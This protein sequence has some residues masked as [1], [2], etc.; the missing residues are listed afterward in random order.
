MADISTKMS[1]TGLS[2]YKSAMTQAQQSVKTLDAELKKNEAAYKASGDKEEYMSNKA[3]ILEQRIKAQKEAAKQAEQAL[4]AMTDQGVNPA[5]ASYQKMQ[6]AL[7]QAQTGVLDT[8]ASL[9]Q[10]TTGEQTAAAGADQL[11]ASVNG[12]NKKVSLDAVIGG[13]DK[14]TSGLEN[15]A[16]KALEVG[17]TIWNEIMNKAQW[18]DDTATAAMMLDMNVEDYQ[19]Y[20]AVFDTVGELTVQDWMKAKKKVQQAIYDP[21][22]DQIDVFA[23]LGLSTRQLGM[24]ENGMIPTL[25][26]KDW[27]TI[28][29]DA[30]AELQRRVQNG[31]LTQDQADV[32]AN[33]LFGKNFTSLKGLLKLGREGFEDAYNDQTAASEDAVN[34]MAELNDKIIELKDK[35]GKLETEVMAGLAPALTTASDVL[36]TLLDKL[37]TFLKSEA[38]QQLLDDMATAVSGL[39][40]DLSKI[41]P[42][43][44]V[45]GFTEVFNTIVE[46]FK[47]LDENKETLAGALGVIVAGWAGAKITGGALTIINMLNGLR[48]LG[49]I[50]GGGEAAGAAVGK[51]IGGGL[52]NTLLHAAAPAMAMDALVIGTAMLPAIIANNADWAKAEETRTRQINV[53]RT[54]DGTNAMWLERTA[55]AL[56]LQRDANG[57]IVKGALG[58][59]VWGNMGETEKALMDLSSRQNQQMAELQSIIAS[60]APTTSSGNETWNE[61]MRFWGGEEMD[62]SRIVALAESVAEA[63]EKSLSGENA[64][65]VEV[66]PVILTEMAQEQL[67]A[68]G[69]VV[70]ITPRISGITAGVGAGIGF[71]GHANGLPFVPWDGYLAMLHRGERVLTASQNASY[72]Y[73]SNTYFG[74]VNLNNGLE[75]EALS[76]SI[77]RHNRKTRAGYGY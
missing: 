19:K 3:K 25:V 1:V 2:Q 63:M 66:K 45:S 72:T 17:Q 21:T 12:I 70:P 57:N 4:K 36:S 52:G 67:N 41:D 8:T 54:A 23:A 49:I 28:F 15:A 60:F 44:V 5:S 32:Y 50:S 75:V 30:S 64:P 10:L 71:M 68:A 27:E 13:I 24:S 29:W 42:E 73:N 22:A 69:L 11:T 7:L 62:Q 46:S 6:Q 38:G 37:M 65:E 76:E 77:D 31:S 34:K 51:G 55:N 9:N 56:G 18:A 20:K 58:Q 26:A 40:E 35:F 59:S 16:K 47:W 14:I 53:A 48:E 61:L 39:F 43:S 33:A 74:N